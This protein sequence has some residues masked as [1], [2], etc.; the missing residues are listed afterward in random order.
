MPHH[1]YLPLAPDRWMDQVEPHLPLLNRIALRLTGRRADAEDLMQ[2]LLLKLHMH[3]HRL[4]S[5]EELRPW[6]VRTLYHHFVDQYR[7][8]KGS[9][10]HGAE[11][12]DEA[13][14]G[15]P[16]EETTSGM[17][18][19][20]SCADHLQLRDYLCTAMESLSVVQREVIAGHD[21][22]GC[23][24]PELAQRLQMSVHTLKSALTRARDRLR[25]QLSHYEPV[26]ARLNRR[27]L[28][29]GGSAPAFAVLHVSPMR[30][31]CRRDRDPGHLPL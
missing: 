2:G 16:C 19:P 17:T 1:D 6:L 8:H 12:Y 18:G 26:P 28:S 31:R 10:E 25:S 20:E 4:A 30:R 21:L 27:R 22:A 23:S 14:E 24:L 7:R 5:V 29:R 15:Q 9:V 3:R 11:S 13:T